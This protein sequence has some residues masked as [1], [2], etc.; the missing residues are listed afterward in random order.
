[1]RQVDNF[2]EQQATIPLY[3]YTGVGALLGMASTE[4]L[5]ASSISYMNDSTEI[6]HACETVGNVLRTR[7]AF[8][9]EN[10]E[11]NFLSQF[12]NWTNSC[13][14]TAHT[15][16]IFSLSEMPSLLSQWRSYTPHGKGVSLGFSSDK[17][18]FIMQASNLKL[19]R[20]IYD[21][22]EQE[23]VI[24]ALIE[25]LLISFRQQLPTMDVCRSQS[26]QSYYGFI[27]QYTNEI[28]QVLSI[29]KHGAFKEEREWRLVSPHYPRYT[30]PQIK[31]REGASMLVPYMELPLGNNKPYFE[32][33]ILG[34]S[35]HQNLSMSGLS[36]FLT[37]KGLCQQVSNCVIPYREW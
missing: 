24:S 14:N 1:M 26:S 21:R 30:D 23:E 29:I 9:Q 10:E 8:G 13:K 17:I 6:V 35:S 2:F 36:M 34:P 31:F 11:T 25:K 7:L 15:I 3:H 4:S 12:Q 28:F 32:K 19:A 16:F 37:N 22:D 5:W 33:V 27:Q 18:N 20:C